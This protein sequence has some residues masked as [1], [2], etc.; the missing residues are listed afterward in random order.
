MVNR[1][2]YS[3]N[4]VFWE[5]NM[6]EFVT[7]A[8]ARDILNVMIGANGQRGFDRNNKTLMQL[9]ED[10]I[11][12]KKGDKEV[13]DKIINVYGPMVRETKYIL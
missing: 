13:V 1:K 5:V 7:I 4:F 12:F 6:N 8:I 10:E 3:S 9:L 11:A 2:I